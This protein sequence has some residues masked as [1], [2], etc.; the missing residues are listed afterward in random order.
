M[1]YSN[2]ISIITDEISQDFEHALDV[3]AEYEIN[4]VD[5]R[6]LWNKN[7]AL[8]DDDELER[9]H[10]ALNSRNMQINVITSP[11]GKCF[12]PNSR[13]STKSKQSLLRNPDFNLGL[14]ERILEISDFFNTSNIRIFSFLQKRKT[15]IKDKWEEMVRLIKPYVK[16]AEALGKTLLL[17]NDY[18]M[19]VANI[20]NTKRFFE[21][22]NS[23]AVK[24]I[25]DPGNFYMEGDLTTVDAY[26][27][28]YENSLVDHIH[29]KDPKYMIPGITAIFTVVGAGHINYEAIF[30]QAIDFG[31]KGY[32][33]LET[34]ALRNKER[35]SRKSIMNMK[36][37]L[38]VL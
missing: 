16:R 34:H 25:L 3:A 17:E 29:I 4:T 11:F 12:F 22:L 28:F 20:E 14:F 19:M 33:C 5:V 36:S 35:T 15:K 37:I 30:K 7:I 38:K 6:T 13:L 23:E 24:L 8:L 9:M 21:D 18:G 10:N 32:F 1:N 27:Y 26:E 2:H 31:Y